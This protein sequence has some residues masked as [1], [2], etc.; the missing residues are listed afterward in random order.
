MAKETAVTRANSDKQKLKDQKI[1]LAGFL[2][3]VIFF[4]RKLQDERRL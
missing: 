1:L 4:F 3:E 2:A